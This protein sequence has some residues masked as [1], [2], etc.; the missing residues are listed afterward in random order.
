MGGDDHKTTSA[1]P[2]RLGPNNL[3]P[4]PTSLNLPQLKVQVKV[5]YCA[6]IS[7]LVALGPMMLVPDS[8]NLA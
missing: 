5:F 8:E 4:S 1:I 6:K 7:T 3:N 2:R